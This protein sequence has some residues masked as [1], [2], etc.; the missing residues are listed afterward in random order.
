MIYFFNLIFF[1]TYSVL[2][3]FINDIYIFGIVLLL[4]LIISL[5]IKIPFKKH[6]K[7]IK[8]N[9]TFM[10]F[11][12]IC[13][14]FFNNIYLAL[15][16]GIRLFLVIDYT[17]IM[18]YYFDSTKIRIA[19]KYLLYPLKLFKINID[20]LTLVIAISLSFIPI[21]SDEVHMIKL[22]LHSK[23]F[24]FN[25]KN[26]STKPYIYLITFL[27]NL[28]DRLDELDKSLNTKAY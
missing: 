10:M 28:F 14:L 22:S 2:L 23:G 5:I 3:F 18:G 24:E 16:V 6:F 1:F 20:N 9:L 25:L 12:I 8:K 11:I 13:N 4:N 7:I 26:V 15:L 27:N 19:F 17:Y 21:L